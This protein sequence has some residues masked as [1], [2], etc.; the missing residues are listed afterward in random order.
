LRRQAKHQRLLLAPQKVFGLSI[1]DFRDEVLR[2]E[3]L[4]AAASPDKP[5]ETVINTAFEFGIN[6]ILYASG[7][8]AVLFLIIGSIRFIMS[9]GN[10]DLMTGAKKTIKYAL[11]GL[12]VVV[13]AFAIV[14]NIID[15]IYKTTT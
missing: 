3:N 5:A 12:A 7:S 4:P 11:I 14:E 2:P 10:E 6:L 15:L 9:F 1:D 8:V 13:L